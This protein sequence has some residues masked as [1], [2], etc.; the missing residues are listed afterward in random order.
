[1]E[2]SRK[3]ILNIYTV[4]PIFIDRDPI[5]VQ[6]MCFLWLAGIPVHHKKIEVASSELNKKKAM[7]SL[8]KEGLIG[9]RAKVFKLTKRGLET[10]ESFLKFSENAR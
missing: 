6:L 9:H 3:T 2:K 8:F 7:D 4:A 5:E 10:V 1:M